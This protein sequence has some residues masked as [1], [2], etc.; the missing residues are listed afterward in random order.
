MPR[1]RRR[2][3]RNPALPIFPS[4]AYRRLIMRYENRD[5]GY[6]R[7]KF[8]FSSARIRTIAIPPPD[9]S[10]LASARSFFF[11]SRAAAVA[12][13]S[14]SGDPN[15]ISLG[16]MKRSPPRLPPPAAA[17]LGG[18]LSA[19]ARLPLSSRWRRQSSPASR[20]ASRRRD[21][22]P[23]VEF[24]E[25]KPIAPEGRFAAPESPPLIASSNPRCLRDGVYNERDR[26]RV[27]RFESFGFGG[28]SISLSTLMRL[29]STGLSKEPAG[30][31]VYPRDR[32]RSQGR[33]RPPEARV[34]MDSRGQV[35]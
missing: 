15:G 25:T 29:S 3:D 2:K 6:A 27:L 7:A 23:S 22:A 33:I 8:S 14:P 11:D 20:P 10:P 21:I 16:L 18:S 32:R 24:I 26:N 19:S 9:E 12:F 34:P 31:F 13:R 35:R 5:R 17:I 30:N 1:R 28:S 4:G